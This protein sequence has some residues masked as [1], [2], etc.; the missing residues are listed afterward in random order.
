MM[1]RRK[2]EQYQVIIHGKDLLDAAKSNTCWKFE[3]SLFCPLKVRNLSGINI[4]SNLWCYNLGVTVL[5]IGSRKNAALFYINF[6]FIS[7]VKQGNAA[8]ERSG[9]YGKKSAATLF[10][11][12]T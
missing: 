2:C 6:D 10:F 8:I 1:S 3:E 4:F 5:G 9:N 7:G 11:G 12:H